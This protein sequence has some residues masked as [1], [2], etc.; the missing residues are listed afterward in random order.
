MSFKLYT[1]MVDVH[2]NQ[3][4][5]DKAKVPDKYKKKFNQVFCLIQV[6]QNGKNNRYSHMLLTFFASLY[7]RLYLRVD[8]FKT[9]S[10]VSR[11]L[12]KHPISNRIQHIVK[13]RG[14]S[15]MLNSLKKYR[16]IFCNFWKFLNIVVEPYCNIFLLKR[17]VFVL[18][19]SII[20][21]FI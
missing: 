18:K 1:L 17:F 10:G 9:V 3:V 19:Y 12:R 14:Q 16:K 6:I 7:E 15:I 8:Y 11:S 21:Y 5:F 20:L 13:W 2:C 4:H